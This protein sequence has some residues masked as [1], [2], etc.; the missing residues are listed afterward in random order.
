V[1]AREEILKDVA[2]VGRLAAVPTIL[3]VVSRTTG[4]RFAA[5]ARVTDTTWTACAI[6][7]LVSFGR[8]AS[9]CPPRR[10]G[11]GDSYETKS[12]V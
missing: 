12:T 5:V 8:A 10:S 4:M 11:A 9:C 6:Y 3:Q 2:A 1:P 7:D